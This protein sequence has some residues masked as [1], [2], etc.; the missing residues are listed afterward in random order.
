VKYRQFGALDFQV[1][2][3]GF[4]CMRLPLAGT[5]SSRIDEPEAIAMIRHAIDHGVN[6]V[7]TAYPYH[8]GRSEVVLGRA[9][10]GGY[11]DRVKVATK[12]PTF[13]VE[14]YADF[15]RFLEEQLDRLGI[16]HID[17]YLLHALSWKRWPPVRDLGVLDWADRALETGKIGH[18]G[19][20]FHDDLERF[21]EIVDGYERWSMCLVQHNYMNEDYQ[22]GSRGIRYAAERGLA[23]VVMEPLLGGSLAEAP[24]AVQELWD[25][26]PVRRTPAEWALQWVWNK[27]EVACVLSG[28]STMEQVTR[29]L[30]S[31]DRA[32][33]G[34][35]TQ[36]ELTVVDRVR[37]RYE[38]LR[39]IPCTKCGYCMPCPNG[40]DIPGNFEL[41]NMVKLF[42]KPADVRK[43]W[44][45]VRL[46]DE[47]KASACI[48]CGECE[49]HCPQSIPISE[50]MPRVHRTMTAD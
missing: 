23:V 36:E 21:E 24:P 19:F 11:R 45:Q 9:L 18:I 31:A 6:Y 50:W 7:D 37:E 32:E 44:Y 1:S 10:A 26:A 39:P 5:D 28:M 49:E 25:S 14:K 4:G 35:L 41:Y 43:M 48:Q 38:E 46:P 13:F 20:S 42:E 27:P 30:E 2:A 8:G 3:L 12:M 47:T 16:D 33:P 15:D 17:F 34:S 29:N 22:A 40:V